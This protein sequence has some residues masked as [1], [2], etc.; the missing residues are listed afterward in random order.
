MNLTDLKGYM[1]VMACLVLIVCRPLSNSHQLLA[2]HFPNQVTPE[3]HDGVSGIG[4]GSRGI[5]GRT[6]FMFF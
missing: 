4:C 2:F 1:E 3:F 6:V 5:V